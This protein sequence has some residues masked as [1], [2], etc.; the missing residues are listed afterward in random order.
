MPLN[1]PRF[2]HIAAL[3]TIL[4]WG[5]TYVSTKVLLEE[6][7][8]IEILFTRFLIGFLVLSLVFPSRLR[9]KNRRE[10]YLFIAAG[11]SGITLYYLLENI[12]LT[13]TTAS[14][15]G[16][17]IALAP[18]FTACLSYWLLK[19]EKPGAQFYIGFLCAITGIC[20]ISGGSGGALSINV[21]GDLLA[22]LAAL[23]WA[24]YSVLVRKIGAL[25]Y[26]PIQATRRIFFYGLVGMIPVVALMDFRLGL[27]RY[28]DS[29]N[30]ANILFLSLGASAL[31]FV[32]WNTAVK[33]LGA[34]KTSVYIYLSPVVTVVS[35]AIVLGER[36]T[37][38]MIF[39]TCL[40]LAG[41]WL[42]ETK[43][44]KWR[45]TPKNPLPGREEGLAEEL[46]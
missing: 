42:S 23:V 24:V 15:A 33:L 31:C 28:A 14:N 29:V 40:T 25:G 3:V 8:P 5:T 41:L 9:L 2:G 18:F 39:G 34:V 20:L 7:S 43:S 27:E 4:L 10:V 22:A 26:N 16:V 30:L 1:S 19:T 38:V 44:L 32:T 13:M 17:I 6:F 12:A 36:M 21:W 46:K 37:G 45:L 35:A 11:I